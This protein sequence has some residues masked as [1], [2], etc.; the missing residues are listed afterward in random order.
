MRIA[1]GAQRIGQH[2]PPAVHEVAHGQNPWTD[3]HVLDAVFVTAATV[4]AA[5]IAL[6]M[7]VYLRS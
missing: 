4:T 5:L 6:A 2:V 1:P 7:L 3:F